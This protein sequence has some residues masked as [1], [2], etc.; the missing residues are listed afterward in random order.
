VPHVLIVDDHVVVRCGLKQIFREE[1]R[2]A[3]FGE[4]GNAAK[5]LVE[6]SKRRWDLL[7]LA[8]PLR[9]K[10]GFHTLTE[11]HSRHP[12]IK[13]LIFS[14]SRDPHHAARA[15]QLGALGYLP[16]DASRS[17]LVQAFQ[18][19]LAGKRHVRGREKLAP[20]QIRSN[21]RRPLST[22]EDMVIRRL[23]AGKRPKEI[24]AE[25]KISVKTVNTYKRR[26][27]DKLQLQSTADLVRYVD[28]RL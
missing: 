26:V 8:I 10:D 14:M 18:N 5:A 22:R 15:V 6:A 24:A 27:L 1:F 9:G 19:V 13:V 12:E 25:L 7:I 3:A 17:Q 16:K 23:A 2:D 28:H 20:P 4:A 21:G 11:I